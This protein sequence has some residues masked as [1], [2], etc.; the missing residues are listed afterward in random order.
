MKKI[1]YIPVAHSTIVQSYITV[2]PTMLSFEVKW[3][4]SSQYFAKSPLPVTL[5]R[6]FLSGHGLFLVCMPRKNMSFEGKVSYDS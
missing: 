2:W 4:F 1:L 5:A 3:Y 6:A